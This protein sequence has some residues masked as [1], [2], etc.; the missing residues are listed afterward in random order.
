M[1]TQNTENQAANVYTTILVNALKK[2]IEERNGE[3]AK[4]VFANL[5]AFKSENA[6]HATEFQKEFNSQ[7]TKL[8]IAIAKQ[9]TKKDSK[10]TAAS[11]T[12]KNELNILSLPVDIQRKKIKNALSG[13]IATED[14]KNG[15][16]LEFSAKY[17]KSAILTEYDNM[18]SDEFSNLYRGGSIDVKS[19]YRAIV[20]RIERANKQSN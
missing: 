4:Q 3:N 18:N 13:Y 9:L 7:F 17:S 14:K 6:D 8:E 1:K 19:V 10:N 20:T 12:A 16:V 15:T 2:A 11:E 5:K